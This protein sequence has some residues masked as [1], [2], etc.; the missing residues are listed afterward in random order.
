[1][2]GRWHLR[3]GLSIREIARRMG[4]ARNTIRKYLSS[5]ELDPRYPPRVSP[6]QLDAF[7]EPLSS[8]FARE[9]THRDLSAGAPSSSSTA[10]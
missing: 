2:I 10:T 6:S 9:A 7:K 3:E 8:W 5:G 1:M 4:L